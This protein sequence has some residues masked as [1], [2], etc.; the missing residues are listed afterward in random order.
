VTISVIIPTYQEKEN[1]GKLI[2]SLETELRKLGEE[3]SIVVCDDKSPDGTGEVVQQL[4]K[5]QNN[6]FLLEGEKRGYGKAIVR[7]YQFAARKLGS[8]IS[9][10]MDADF[11]HDPGQ[12]DRL[13]KAIEIGA[14]FVI[15]SRYVKGGKINAEW[16]SFRRLNSRWGN[17]F[18]RY[19]VGIR[20]V[21]DCTSGFRAIR[22]DIIK[23]I[24]PEDIDEKGYSFLVRVLYEAQRKNAKVVE[25]PIT[26]AD[27]KSGSTKL[28]IWDIIEFIVMSLKIGL[29]RIVTTLRGK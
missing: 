14:D 12:I 4:S 8:D 2:V 25:V 20:K 13:I 23:R 1:I 10:T 19:L 21:S 24:K 5:K 11:S 27:R 18:A 26:F 17:R 16:G 22:T 15:G 7:G 9:I 6:I 28:G 29:K 3:F